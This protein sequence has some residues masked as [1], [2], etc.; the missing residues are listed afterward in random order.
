MKSLVYRFV[1][2]NIKAMI[3]ETCS[4]SNIRAVFC[5]TLEQLKG[6]AASTNTVVDDWILA[7]LTPY[8]ES[9]EVAERFARIVQT[10]VDCCAATPE[11]LEADSELGTQ[12]LQDIAPKFAAWKE[13]EK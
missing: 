8:A 9:E 3:L 5:R 12:L 1:I 6:Y 11:T 4:A 13:L 7:T 2:A 10:L